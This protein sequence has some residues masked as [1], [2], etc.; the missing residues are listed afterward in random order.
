[1]AYSN[2]KELPDW[3]RPLVRQLSESE[4]KRFYMPHANIKRGREIQETMVGVIARMHA[5]GVPEPRI[6]QQ[7]RA[8]ATNA[9]P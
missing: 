2:E 8:L 1:M 6:M 5:R 3:L 9:W 7:L 4:Q